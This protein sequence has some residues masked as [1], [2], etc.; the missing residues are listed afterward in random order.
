VERLYAFFIVIFSKHGVERFK[1]EIVLCRERLRSN[2]ESRLSYDVV[3][4]E[5]ID[6]TFQ[7]SETDLIVNQF[8]GIRCLHSHESLKDVP[9]Q[10]QSIVVD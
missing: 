10:T 8:S 4:D 1:P 5:F 6:V 3:F 9:E 2:V 7:D